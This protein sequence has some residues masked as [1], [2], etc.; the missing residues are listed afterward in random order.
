MSSGGA[1]RPP[2]DSPVVVE[3][4]LAGSDGWRL[5]ASAAPG[6]LEGY[7]GQTSVQHG[8]PI[9]F[10]VRADGPHTVRW[11]AWRMGW[12]GGAQGR[13][14]ASGGPLPVGPQP[15]PAPNPSTGLVECAWPVTF[16]IETEPSWTS[17]VYMARLVRDDGHDSYVPFVVR[18]DERKGAAVF[19][20]S[21]TTYE[22]YNVWGGT[23]LYD[24]GPAVEVSF[25]RPFKEGNGSAQYFW[26]EHD[27][28]T[29]AESRGLDLTYVT[30]VDVDRE[31]TLLA[32]QRL[33]LSVGHDEYWSRREREGV[34]AA[35]ASG[36]SLAFFS[37]NSAYWQIRIEPSRRDDRPGRTE[38]CYKARAGT[39]D[40]MRGTPLETTKW[41]LPPVNQPEAALLGVQ[42]TAWERKSAAWVVANASAWPYEGAGV[43]D[44]DAIPGIVG[45][46]TDRTTDATPPGAT[47]LSRSPV[48][49]VMGAQDVQEGAV[50]D[51]P[52]GTFV[53][54]AGTIQWS[55]GLSRPGVV[56]ARVQ[57]V[58]ENV[59]RRAGVLPATASSPVT[60]SAPDG[61]PP[62]PSP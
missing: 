46:E 53:F 28:V 49:D 26:Y 27:F 43:S 21:F 54:A 23:S 7:A 62:P 34:E 16:T 13:L 2:P 32:G 51:L 58:T 40:P 57:R 8:E 39:Q 52:N 12:Y 1:G 50:R 48:V 42:F 33:F 59:F 37:A 18:A 5:R 44:G 4:R 29:W 41:R 25:D 36:T 22:A 38:V 56:D 15:G 61:G 30:N 17:G 45:Y 55:W 47:T 10:H 60:S 31:P 3:N 35:L 20:A 6:Q 9:D 11:E 24:N 14:V 19:Q